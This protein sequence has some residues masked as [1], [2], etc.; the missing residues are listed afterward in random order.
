MILRILAGLFLAASVAIAQQGI[1]STV[2]LRVSDDVG[3]PVTNAAVDGCF[4]DFS[5]SGA[6]TRFDGFTDTNGIFM[7]KGETVLGVYARFTCDGYYPTT[8]KQ[9]IEYTRKANGKGYERI[10]RW[11]RDIPVLL[12]RIR[13]P[14]SMLVKGIQNVEIRKKSEDKMGHYV[15]NSV[16]GYDLLR[17]DMLPPY[18]RGMLNDLEFDWKMTISATNKVGRAIDYDTLC[19]I[20]LTNTVDGICRGPPDG[21]ENGQLGSA[22][23]S[24]YVAPAD[25]YTNA[26]TFYRNVHGTSAES[27]DDQHYLYYFRIRTQTNEMG[28]VTNA[29]YGKIQGKINGLFTYYLNPTPNDRNVEFDPKRNLFKDLKSTEQV[30][31]P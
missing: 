24:A 18:G 28:Q 26:I 6:R 3:S 1:P 12:K 19:E 2:K 5:Q 21:A 30:R 14:I 10:D 22:Y 13:N 31:E 25:G 9:T 16:V 20:R 15:L 4:L 29:L 8:V 23:I 17:G 11:D 27:N 7:A